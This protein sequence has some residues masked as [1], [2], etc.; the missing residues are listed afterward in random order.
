MYST[1]LME[2]DLSGQGR[3]EGRSDRVWKRREVGRDEMRQ[4][5]MEWMEG[6]VVAE[7]DGEE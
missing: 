1:F 4:A 7:V 3:K 2:Q 5:K 6:G